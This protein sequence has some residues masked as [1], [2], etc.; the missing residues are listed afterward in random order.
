[1]MNTHVVQLH[2]AN[3]VLLVVDAWIHGRKVEKVYM[4]GGAQVCAMMKDAM[5]HLRLDIT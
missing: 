4:D 5:H 3:D 2:K 1:M